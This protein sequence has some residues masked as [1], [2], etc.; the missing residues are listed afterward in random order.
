EESALLWPADDSAVDFVAYYPYT[1]TIDDATYP[2]NIADQSRP[3]LID[4]MWTNATRGRKASDGNPSLRFE[5]RLAR[6]VFNI[7]DGDRT[8]LEGL[9]A[10]LDGL[11]T[12]ADFS[13]STGAMS[14]LAGAIVFEGRLVGTDDLDDDGVEESALVEAIVVP[15]AN[16]RFD[17]V[18]QL[19]DDGGRALFTETDGDYEAGKKYTYNITLK[20][21][22]ESLD[23]GAEG[24]LNSIADWGT[25]SERN[26]EIERDDNGA[27]NNSPQGTPWSSGLFET[28]SP[29]YTV[30][31]GQHVADSGYRMGNGVT[32]TI[33]RESHP[34]PVRSVTV[35]LRDG[36]SYGAGS[37]GTISSVKV[38]ETNF[39]YGDPENTATSAAVSRDVAG[40]GTET[41]SDFIFRAPGGTPVTGPIE[42]TIVT[43]VG[44][45]FARSFG[46]N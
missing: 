2:V 8:S 32:I 33:D 12:R 30:A 39:V 15:G 1:A 18:L 5:H 19:A 45:M 16:Q 26:D 14:G 27:N 41:D 29:E 23:F 20:G 6:L 36:M 21:R 4:L 9:T 13:L 31:G 44:P 24:A 22:R 46:V 25:G 38:G 35:T 3:E 34:D 7:T 17:L 28:S 42:I 43:T 11:P 10:T 40:F 37:S